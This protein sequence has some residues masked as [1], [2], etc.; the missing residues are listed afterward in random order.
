MSD[1]LKNAHVLVTGATGFVGQA[2]VE[3]LLSAYPSTRLTLLVRPR[4]EVTAQERVTQLLEKDCFAPWRERIGADQAADE[5]ARRINVLSG[6][7]DNVPALPGDLD[8]VIHSAS[9]VSFDLPID[10]AFNTNLGGPLNLYQAVA[11]SGS[12]PHVVHVSTCYVA[13]LRKG[14]VEERSLEIGRAHV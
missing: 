9:T 1:P 13:G 11:A 8:V 5:I 4:G 2:V 3:K 7:L 14:L 10:E 6:D 12:D